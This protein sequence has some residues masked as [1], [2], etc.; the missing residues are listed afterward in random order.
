M[1]LA[2]TPEAEEFRVEIRDVARGEPAAGWSTT[3]SR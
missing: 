2:Y 3:A 1:D